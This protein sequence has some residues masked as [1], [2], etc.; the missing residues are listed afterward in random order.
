MN[1]I[2]IFYYSRTGNTEKMAKAVEEGVRMVNGVEV[3]LTYNV[4]LEDLVEYDAI[5]VGAPTYHHDMT[6]GIKKLF[7]DAALKNINLKDKV[8]TAFG[9]YGWSGEAPKLILEIMKNKFKMN[10]VEGPLHIKYVPDSTGLAKC[11]EF[12]KGIAEKIS[13]KE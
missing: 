3:D 9:S 7:E 6:V 10:I 5:V 12:G 11:R 2:L 13:A 8:G 4:T 1:K